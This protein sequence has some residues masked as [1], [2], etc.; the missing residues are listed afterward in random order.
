M[1]DRERMNRVREMIDDPYL[2]LIDKFHQRMYELAVP[3]QIIVTKEEVK[4]IYSDS[5]KQAIATIKQIR[6]QYVSS[7]YRDLFEGDP[8]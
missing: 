2:R 1:T 7:T 4:T 3:D 8:E 6:D 5:F